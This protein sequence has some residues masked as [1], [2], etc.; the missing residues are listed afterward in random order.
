MTG[1]AVNGYPIKC[2]STQSARDDPFSSFARCVREGLYA[3]DWGCLE[4]GG[5]IFDGSDRLN[6]ENTKRP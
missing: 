4:R 6:L 1:I 2:K 5:L 3:E